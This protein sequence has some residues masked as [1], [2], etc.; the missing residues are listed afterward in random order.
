MGKKHTVSL[1]KHIRGGG[2]PKQILKKGG[3]AGKGARE[4]QAWLSG[5]GDVASRG[6]RYLSV[7]DGRAVGEEGAGYLSAVLL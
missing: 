1:V 3:E 2:R 4:G 6:G 7:S 5:C